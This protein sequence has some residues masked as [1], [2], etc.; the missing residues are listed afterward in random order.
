[1]G[2]DITYSCIGP[3]QYRVFL[4]FFR[5]CS[6][7]DPD[8]SQMLTYS[9]VTCNVSAEVP[10]P[11]QSTF[12]D[13]TPICPS[14]TSA[15]S[16]G[17]SPFG[18]EQHTYEVVI[19]LPDGCGNDWLLTW[20]QCCRNFGIT[21][22][23]NP[24][25]LDLFVTANLDNT[26]APCNN[27]PV[28]NN[29]PTP[30]VCDGV[31][32]V[33][34]HSV[35]DPDGDSLVFSLT[36]CLTDVGESVPYAGGHSAVAPLATASGVTLD[37]VTGEIRFTP[38][39]IQIGVICVQVEEFR[40]GVK[41]GEVVR[42]MQ[43]SVVNCNNTPPVSSGINGTSSYSISVC[44]GSN[45]CFDIF[46][47]DINGDNIEMAWNNGIPNGTFTITNNGS[48]APGATFCW[49]TTANDVGTHF[50][51]VE[52]KDDAC[53]LRGSRI[54]SYVIEVFETTNT[55]DA[56]PDETICPGQ[57]TTLNPTSTGAL[58]YSWTPT[59]GLSAPNIASPTASPAITTVYSLTTT[60]SDGCELTD[61][62]TVAV[63][64][65]PDLNVSPTARY[66]CPGGSVTL[67]ADAPGASSYLWSN[68]TTTPTTT[69]TPAST[70][71]YSVTI[72]N[73]FGCMNTDSAIV[74]VNEPSSNA[75]VVVYASPTGTGAGT[76]SDPASLLDA[77]SLASCSNSIIKMAVGTY[78]IDNPITSIAGNITLEGG[79]EPSNGWRKTSR[80]G[81]TTIFR[82]AANPEGL[83]NQ[84]RIVGIYLNGASNFR[85]QDLTIETDHAIDPGTSTYG[86]HLTN[87]SDYQFV[88]C[89]I[90]AGD[91]ADGQAGTN[92]ANGVNGAH[93]DN[94]SNGSADQQ[95]LA[96][97]GGNG[98]DGG[99]NP[100]SGGAAGVDNNDGQGNNCCFS[101]VFPAGPK[102]CCMDGPP[103]ANGL[104]A[105]DLRAG[106]GG[107][108]GAAGGEGPGDG[109]NGG[110]GGANFGL[111][112]TCCG[113]TGG[114]SHNNTGFDGANGTD[115]FDGTDGA[116]GTAGTGMHSGGFWI[117]GNGTDG[118][119]G[120]GGKGGT[121]G[122]GGGGQDGSFVLNGAGNG[123]GGGGG[124]GQGG[125]GGTGGTGGGSSYG[126]Y[127]FMNGAN[128]VFNNC[129]LQ[130]GTA[131]MGGPG[132]PGGTGGL[133]G[134][135]G[136]GA[137]QGNQDV[138]EGGDGGDGGNGG[139]G[140]NGGAGSNG[141]SMALYQNGTPPTITDINFAL[142]T[143][144]EIFMENVSC[145]NKDVDFSSVASGLWDFGPNSAPRNLT[146]A[147][148]TTQ[149]T[150]TGRQT[151]R[152]AADLY[153]D[154][155]NIELP[156]NP[157]PQSASSAR[158]ENNT[159]HICAGEATDFE[160]LNG[161]FN[162]TYHW[163]LDGGATPNTYSGETFQSL[164]NVTFN[165]PGTYNIQ[166]QYETDCCGL[167]E[168]DTLV[169]IVEEQ[170][171]LVLAG[172]TT[173]CTGSGGT[174]LVASGGATYQWAPANGLSATTGDSVL[175]NPPIDFTYTVT[176]FDT[177][178]YCYD[179]GTVNVVVNELSL[180]SITADALCGANGAAE[181]FAT[182][183][184]G[185]Y[186][187][188]WNTNPPSTQSEAVNL[189]SGAY[190]V[191][192]T[193]QGSGCSDSLG[194][195]VSA[196]PSNLTVGPSSL[197][198][199]TCAGFADGSVTLS[200]TG[201]QPGYT[202]TWQNNV[203]TGPTASNLPAGRYGFTVSDQNG[204]V[205]TDTV[206]VSEP[207]PVGVDMLTFTDSD[208]NNFGSVQ[209]NAFGGNGPYQYNWD[210][211]SLTDS[212]FTSG[213]VPDTI[214]TVTV[215]D[216][217][218]CTG[219][220]PF[221][222]VGPQS[223]VDLSVV[224]VQNATSCAVNDGA[225]TV[226]A[227]GGDG[228]Y[229]YTW[230]TNPPLS[231]PS[232]SGLESGTYVIE[233]TDGLG[234]TDLVSAEIG[235]DCPLPVS[236]LDFRAHPEGNLIRLDWLT[237]AEIN[238]SGFE[239]ERSRDSLRFE[240]LGWVNT[241]GEAGGQYR[242]DDT[243]VQFNTRYYYRL[244]QVDVAG[245]F[246]YSSIRSALLQAQH[247]FRVVQVYPIPARQ[248]VQIDVQLP[249]DADLKLRLL[250]A[251]GQQVG[252]YAFSGHRG[253]NNL[254]LDVSQLAAG[255]Y[256]GKLWVDGNELEVKLVKE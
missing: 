234:C 32:V 169:L 41:I 204:C 64:D 229:T 228:N 250:N 13:V 170:P 184:I 180:S 162:Y 114:A 219:S 233:V 244:K 79:F 132:G 21:T 81:A 246:H 245:G 107:G 177:S 171:S 127:L 93:G 253:L 4:T 88:R 201:G 174:T 66:I 227:T 71:T 75:C 69:V 72:Q 196:A 154:F 249:Q 139:N 217:N 218:G 105:P 78:T 10:M 120:L 191:V 214:Y 128:G 240:A 158:L 209:V 86:V 215:T 22:L 199:A 121:G 115:G 220:M 159:Y 140:G 49:P 187:Y 80:A 103:G 77:I 83:A 183:G 73:A 198:P 52:V 226:N 76:Q 124:G 230:Q 58:S 152:Y 134:I 188:S 91:G 166:L 34:N 173:I 98:G 62:V 231:G 221:S 129:N 141:E 1:M 53:L 193:D 16:G 194:V 248:Q 23:N 43:F 135:G 55:L 14:A 131:G 51:T 212:S 182:G 136:N 122:G 144:A 192:V 92:G 40:N 99:G 172:D 252:H 130:A 111:T 126:V 137:I 31:E 30:I 175:A 101:R 12:V 45:V 85:F 42:D 17:T 179:V 232:H 37:P 119:D 189:A 20:E 222:I 109:G 56:G 225:I 241:K 156:D 44:K 216:E 65:I 5:D 256:F 97:N 165:T 28:F 242:F 146:G 247:A 24:G 96:G 150:A 39:G 138:G 11:K 181:V 235:P 3:N 255:V 213:L 106:G 89:Q 208:C 224:S 61:F 161:G 35:T 239:V 7:I 68:G 108:G 100:N 26:I 153:T 90:I 15:C 117:P 190:Q 176:A 203:G 47:T 18:I 70:S 238:N 223:P 236:F 59:T 27:S 151:L 102:S 118:A 36:N 84:Q 2:A 38:V 149:F 164:S 207:S 157:I 142:A 67:T 46:G 74:R 104:D 147:A 186:T 54:Y 237:G 6:G 50:F 160:A 205:V 82:T 145:V 202:Y 197:V 178:G 8:T 163:N 113:G 168:I 155:A 210:H 254:Q 87:C 57:T 110:N 211:P 95:D 63:S 206:E 251:L 143:Q 148:V 19:D 167:S 125:A 116:N 123:G 33:Y 60:F 112:P 25:N 29:I 133:G 195:F 94:G 243:E 9:S 48:T 185:P 200:V